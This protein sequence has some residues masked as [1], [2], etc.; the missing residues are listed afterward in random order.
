[1]IILFAAYEIFV[2][3]Q[4][5]TWR[6]CEIFTIFARNVTYLSHS[7]HFEVFHKYYN[8]NNN[9]NNNNIQIGC[10]IQGSFSSVTELFRSSW[11]LPCVV[12]LLS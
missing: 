3:R 1:M 4:L 7:L 2:G 9:N 11:M 6:P 10:E 8:N 5:Q 12:G